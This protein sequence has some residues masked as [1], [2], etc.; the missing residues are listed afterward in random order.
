MSKYGLGM[1]TT[2][3][4]TLRTY[5]TT[6]MDQVFPSYCCCYYCCRRHHTHPNTSLPTPYANANAYP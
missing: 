2:A 1:M 5:I 3:D 6:I 4:D